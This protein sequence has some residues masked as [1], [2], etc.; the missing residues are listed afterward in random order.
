MIRFVI[1]LAIAFSFGCHKSKETTYYQNGALH[2]E[3]SINKDG[4]KHG[5]YHI[6]SEDGKTME[7]GEYHEGHYKGTRTLFT[8][9]VK[10]IEEFYD[11]NG[12][13]NAPSFI[14]Y[15]DGK[16]KIEK[17]YVNNKINGILKGYYPSGALKEEVTFSDNEENGPFTE[18]HPNGTVHWKGQYLN[19][20][21]EFGLLER[22]D[23]T[24]TLIKKMMCDSMAICR[25]FWKS[26][27]YPAYEED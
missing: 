19:G 12:N 24:G 14:Y 5:K 22:F 6:L 11:D 9:G 10:E 25:T 20:D 8:D 27:N 3:Y 4:I 18:Y 26:D 1:F 7:E 21:N 2:E 23:T 16:I 17:P 13:L 15:P